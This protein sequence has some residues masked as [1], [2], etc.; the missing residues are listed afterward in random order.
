MLRSEREPL[1]I[2]SGRELTVIKDGRPLISRPASLASQAEY[3]PN[4]N[5]RSEWN[6]LGGTGWL[7]G[8]L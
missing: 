4:T 7:W 3:Q 6:W 2:Q 5:G 1:G 8:W